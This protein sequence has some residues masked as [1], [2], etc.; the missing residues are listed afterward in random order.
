MERRLTEEAEIDVDSKKVRQ[1]E[2]GVDK[3]GGEMRGGGVRRV[4]GKGAE[5]KRERGRH[6]AF[7][8]RMKGR[9]RESVWH[10]SDRRT[11]GSAW[12]RHT[13]EGEGRRGGL[14]AAMGGLGWPAT[15]P[16]R[17]ARAVPSRANRGARGLIGGPRPQC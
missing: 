9:E 5:R 11:R 3:L 8:N 7:L 4:D 2:G 15:A 10:R 12:A 6:P 17:Q 13:V 1:P 14:G 16:G